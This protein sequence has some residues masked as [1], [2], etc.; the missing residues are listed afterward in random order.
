MAFNA[1]EDIAQKM[2]A[3]EDYTDLSNFDFEK[4]FLRK[5]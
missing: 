5:M 3:S 2:K 1:K 4:K